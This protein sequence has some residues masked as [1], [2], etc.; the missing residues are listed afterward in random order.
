MFHRTLTKASAGKW[1]QIK[2]QDLKQGD[3][4]RVYEKGMLSETDL[5]VSDLPYKEEDYWQ[6]TTD[7]GLVS[8]KGL[9]TPQIGLRNPNKR[10][11][12]QRHRDVL[13]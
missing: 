4:I 7:N 3:V 9:L 5:V 1:E 11:S 2:W 8:S 10:R 13:K 6:V 12:R